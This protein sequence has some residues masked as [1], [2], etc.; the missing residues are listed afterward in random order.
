MFYQVLM[1][2]VND[3][4]DFCYGAT[5]GSE[6]QHN[7]DLRETFKGRRILEFITFYRNAL[8]HEQLK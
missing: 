4:C 5:V 3:L 8:R 7:E 1:I 6:Q 2:T